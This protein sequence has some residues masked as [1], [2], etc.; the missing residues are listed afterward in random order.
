MNIVTRLVTPLKDGEVDEKG[1]AALVKNQKKHGLDVEIAGKI[2]DGAALSE[3]DL[4]KLIDIA[5][6]ISDGAIKVFVSAASN[7]FSKVLKKV[8]LALKRGVN[9]ITAVLPYYVKGDA[10][11]VAEFYG[12]LSRDLTK[13]GTEFVLDVTDPTVKYDS[14]RLRTS[15]VA[16]MGDEWFC[17]YCTDESMFLFPFCKG[18]FSTAANINPALVK[19]TCA[20]IAYNKSFAVSSYGALKPT[21]DICARGSTAIKKVLA[22][23]SMI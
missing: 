13:N 15:N 18:C 4:T 23:K 16:L 3:T 17:A 14:A 11:T 22:Q 19:Q 6:S 5:M 10:V 1:F 12:K 20:A 21:I 9:G 7:D 8:S 2:G